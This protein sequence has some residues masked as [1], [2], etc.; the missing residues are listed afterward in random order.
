VGEAEAAKRSY[1]AGRTTTAMPAM[2]LDDSNAASGTELSAVDGQLTEI[3]IS[4]PGRQT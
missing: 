2:T 4:W 3:S 1:E